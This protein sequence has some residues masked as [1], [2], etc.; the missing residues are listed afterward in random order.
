MKIKMNLIL[1][2]FATALFFTMFSC[3][4][5]PTEEMNN[6]IAAVARAENDKDVPTYAPNSLS[7]AR[8]ALTNM[9]TE[10]DAKRYDSAKNLAEEAVRLA[11][12][13][14]SDSK[15]ALSRAKDDAAVAVAALEDAVSETDQNIKD[16]KKS[17]QRGID[18][19]QV[20]QDLADAKVVVDEA[21][22][23]NNDSK[24]KEAI[25]KS[26]QARSQLGNITSRLT[27]TVIQTN[28]KK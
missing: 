7:K 1:G 18:F 20:D 9:Q 11:E 22:A 25:G 24:Y 21:V 3:A 16:A 23:A 5:P 15:L 13:A 10:A 19:V 14:V 4:K 26:Q 28:R 27:Q 2:I 17:G 8:E 12:K 6:A